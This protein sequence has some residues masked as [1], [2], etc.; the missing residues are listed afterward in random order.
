M[1]EVVVVFS[2]IMRH[3]KLREVW[4]EDRCQNQGL[5]EPESGSGLGLP[6]VPVLWAPLAPDLV[7]KPVGYLPFL[8]KGNVEETSIY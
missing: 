5:V 7:L 8:T 1:M 6:R 2:T 3:L 4:Q